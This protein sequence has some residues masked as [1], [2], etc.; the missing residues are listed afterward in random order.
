MCAY[1]CMFAVSNC[2]VT[3]TAGFPFT[4]TECAVLAGHFKF[5]SQ[6]DNFNMSNSQQLALV[7]YSKF[8][9]WAT[10]DAADID[11][12]APTVHTSGRSGAYNNVY[13]ASNSSSGNSGHAVL[14]KLQRGMQ[15]GELDITTVMRALRQVFI[16]QITPLYNNK[17]FSNSVSM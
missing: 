6:F 11:T 1:A 17:C 15:R 14:F 13:N 5:K 7:S 3:Q 16:P 12:L 2:T 4:R 8:L 9:S 10:P